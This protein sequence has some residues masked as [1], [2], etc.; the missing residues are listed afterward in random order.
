MADNSDDDFDA[1]ADQDASADDPAAAPDAGKDTVDDVDAATV[2]T[3]AADAA[4]AKVAD[5]AGATAGATAN[6]VTAS[7][8][9]VRIPSLPSDGVTEN[10][11]D[12]FDAVAD[13]DA[14]ADDPAAAPDAG[15]DTVDDVDAATVATAAAD[16]AAAKVADNAGVTAGATAGATANAATAS[17]LTVR[18]P[19]LPSDGVIAVTT[20]SGEEARVH[21]TAAVGS[22]AVS[23]DISG[24]GASPTDKM[25]QDFTA[26]SSSDV[27]EAFAKQQAYASTP[28]RANGSLYPIWRTG[29]TKM[30]TLFGPGVGMWMHTTRTFAKLLLV[31][32]LLAG[33]SLYYYA[34]A[35]LQGNHARETSNLLSI[36][37]LSPVQVA[38][39]TGEGT[40]LD[41][42]IDARGIMTI[43]VILDVVCVALF[44][45]VLFWLNRRH[46][47]LEEEADMSSVTVDDYA[48]QVFGLPRNA[49]VE[50]VEAWF[51]RFGKVAA[52]YQAQDISN[53]IAMRKKLATS[54]RSAARANAVGDTR[55]RKRARAAAQ[56]L[57][58]SITRRDSTAGLGTVGTF[59]VFEEEACAA[60]CRN[61]LPNG[62]LACLTHKK[63]L[64]PSEHTGE[65]D[66]MISVRRAP[67]PNDIL[68]EN[69]HITSFQRFCR[70]LVG[71][72]AMLLLVLLSI[73][74]T[75]VAKEQ[76]DTLNP[77]VQCSTTVYD[78]SNAASTRGL[79][80]EAAWP[81][82]DADEIFSRTGSLAPRM[83][84]RAAIGGFLDALEDGPDDGQSCRHFIKLR[85]FVV[86]FSDV[87]DFSAAPPSVGGAW[88]GGFDTTTWADE[89]AAQVCYSCYCEDVGFLAWQRDD[90]DFDARPFCSDYWRNQALFLVYTA[91]VLVVVAAVNMVLLVMSKVMGNFERHATIS[92]R[93]RAVAIKLA[94]ALT[95][96][97][98]VVPVLTYAYVAPLKDV[99][100]LFSGVHSDVNATWHDLV[101]TAIV[102]SAIINAIT[103]PL[104]HYAKLATRRLRLCCCR[105]FAKTQHDLNKLYK[106]P[107]FALAERTGQFLSVLFYTLMLS[108]GAP[109]LWPIAGMY[110][111][112][113]YYVD[114]RM[115][116][117][118]VSMPPRYSGQLSRM[119]RSVLPF[120]AALHILLS[121][122][123]FGN[124]SL[125]SYRFEV[126]CRDDDED[127]PQRETGVDD[128]ESEA[129]DFDE[130]AMPQWL[131]I[132]LGV[133][134][135]DDQFDVSARMCRLNGIIP[136]IAF[137]WLL[138]ILS[139]V[140]VFKVRA[141]ARARAQ[142]ARAQARARSPA[143]HTHRAYTRVRT[144]TSP[145]HIARACADSPPRLAPQVLRG[146]MGTLCQAFGLCNRKARLQGCPSFSEALRIRLLTGLSSYHAHESPDYRDLFLGRVLSATKSRK[147]GSVI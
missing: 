112:L 86:D 133:D 128:A 138:A 66:R 69:L 63:L 127:T 21:G 105:R 122:W 31:T 125:P 95:I 28:R 58:V 19:S 51:G 93:D 3:A 68:W 13:Q 88:G 100:L 78:S 129:A 59:V 25:L 106:P 113:Q 37:G 44:L 45:L 6:A 146:L 116:L 17:A 109:L 5:N 72:F 144:R 53:T 8:L 54:L 145:L 40:L 7:A 118:S 121:I 87:A 32:T 83:T 143:A 35:A 10:S 49:T 1:V 90:A 131:K 137:A 24:A 110:C 9:T 84:T 38:Y 26:E 57:H 43:I 119:M 115:L 74:A 124:S 52:V 139:I 4:A 132:R 97:T 27:N 142:G 140:F 60:R 104:A 80:C 50:A 47:A 94:V 103:F 70:S 71:N 39:T 14:S 91:M 107:K 62:R 136:A 30:G 114:K 101:V 48:V 12:D 92:G 33:L 126:G 46:N 73:G 56:D 29:V 2:A 65:P 11:D 64:F 76:L 55:G 20:A 16:A 141:C 79:D 36:L 111:V 99:P 134:D 135:I 77:N 117:R 75:T 67:P 22:T 120:A 85:N 61:A 123:M 23:V 81:L 34:R 18:I 147:G 130:G 108:S 15:K 89:C 42:G 102:T 98:A 96:N 41:L 82:R